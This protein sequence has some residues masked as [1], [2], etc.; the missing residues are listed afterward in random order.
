[1]GAPKWEIR[2][3][4]TLPKGRKFEPYTPNSTCFLVF[5]K[6]GQPTKNVWFYNVDGDGSS[7]RKARKFGPQYRND[8][9]DL[10]TKWP[11]CATEGGRAWLMPASKIIANGHNMTLA[12]L[13]LVEPE[14]TD[15]ADPEDILAAMACKERR[16]LDI[17]KEMRGLLASEIE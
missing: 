10:L 2:S 4:I 14:R 9:P 15:H 1:M 7:L 16:I 3:R 5:R 11:T 13:D 12:S 8:F 17:V 6:T